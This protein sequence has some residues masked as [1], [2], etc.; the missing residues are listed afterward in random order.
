MNNKE[1]LIKDFKDLGLQDGDVVFIR[2]NL[3]KMGRLKPRE[4]FLDALFEV[5]GSNGTVVTLGFTKSFPFYKVDKSYIFDKNTIPDTGAF[6]K[7]CLS[8]QNAKRSKH[9]TNSFIAI[10]KN[11]EKVLE[12]HDENAMLYDPTKILIELNA[13][14]IIFGIIDESPGFTTVHYV[15]QE[16]GLTKKSFFKNLFRVYYKNEK[17]EIKL[18][19]KSDVGGCSAGFGKF[20]Q[21]YLSSG[22]LRTGNIGNSSALLIHAQDAYNIEYKLMK[23][24]N[25]FHF[26]DNPLCISCRLSWK[27]DLKYSINYLLLKVKSLFIRKIKK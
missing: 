3:G 7:L 23:K 17:N 24:N 27:Y 21:Y 8:Y 18:F 22:F 19:K 12:N 14:M 26:C 16:L 5:I 4:L 20:Y 1:T 13:K 6:G 9:P 25:S 2:G 15:Q 10:G 11:A